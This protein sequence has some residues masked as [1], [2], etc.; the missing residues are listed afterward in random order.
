MKNVH[1]LTEGAVLL[2]VFAVLLMIS[3]YVPV[4]GLVSTL[5]LPIPF[6]LFAAKNKRGDAAV[7][8]VAA[9]LLSLIVGTILSIPLTLAFGLTGVVIGDFIREKK[10]NSA[11]FI[12][13]SLAFLAILLLTYAA[14]NVLFSIN[15]IDEMTKLMLESMNMSRSIV[16]SMGQNAADIEKAFGQMEAAMKTIES[17]I[18][19][20]LVLSSLSIVFIIQLIAFPIVKRFGVKV[21]A[22]KPF[23]DLSFPKSI[24]WYYLIT[25]FAVLIMQPEAGTF[26]YM[27]L[28]NLTFILQLLMILQGLSFVF[29]YSRL[30]G[31]PKAAPIFILIFTFLIPILLY[32]VRILGIIDIGFDLRKRL[33]KRDA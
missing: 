21:N 12:A 29:F 6:I 30:K 20:V 2:A 5:V 10:E 27:A 8:L 31:W 14:M 24:L 4:L 7:F 9:V 16:E 19:S 33:D 3:F 25:M 17:L 26:W 11:I 28:S 32:I 1:K 23:A 22:W 18:P 13:G 15:F